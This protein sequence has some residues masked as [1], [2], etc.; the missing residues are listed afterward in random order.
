MLSCADAYKSGAE[1]SNDCPAGSVRIE[2]EAACRTAVTA[3][4]K[5]EAST[6]VVTN[7]NFPR[8]CYTGNDQNIRISGWFND[9]AVGAGD[10]RFRPQCAVSTGA[11]RRRRTDA[12]AHKHRRV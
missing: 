12:R 2:T 1:G 9:H 11:R 8:G 7:P 4:C 5:T 6:F 10:S 3:T